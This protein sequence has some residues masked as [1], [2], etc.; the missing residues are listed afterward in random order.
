LSP[1]PSPASGRG[2]SCA[3]EE[4]FMQ[5]LPKALG[6][7]VDFR[8]GRLAV[9]FKKKSNVI[10]CLTPFSFSTPP[11]PAGG[12]GHGVRVELRIRR[13]IYANIAQGFGG[14]WWIFVLEDWLFFSKKIERN[15]VSDTFFDT[16]FLCKRQR[17]WCG[18]TNVVFKP[19]IPG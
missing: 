15:L 14:L 8:A 5:T 2:W 6:T 11:W 13:N 12:I 4:I 1:P 7:V 16:F 3:F 17:R 19:V 9:F 18:G 10:W